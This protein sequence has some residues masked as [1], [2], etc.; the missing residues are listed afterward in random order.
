MLKN[1]KK[2]MLDIMDRWPITLGIFT[3]IVTLVF[4]V[5]ILDNKPP[6]PEHDITW[7]EPGMV[8]QLNQTNKYIIEI[9]FR[10]DGVLMWRLL[11]REKET[12]NGQ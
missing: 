11:T 5:I 8:I 10:D 9:G 6:I 7:A 2:L 1:L 4:L 3:F 12:S